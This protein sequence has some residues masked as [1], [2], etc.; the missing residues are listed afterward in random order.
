MPRPWGPTGVGDFDPY[1]IG[2]QSRKQIVLELKNHGIES[3]SSA[4]FDALDMAVAFFNSNQAMAESSKPAKVRKNIQNALDAALVLNDR[5]N[6]LDGNSRYLMNDVV[7]EGV[8]HLYNSLE[9]IIHSLS[10]ASNLANQYQKNGRLPDYAR[11]WLAVD[12]ASAIKKYLGVPPTTTRGGVFES[13]V[14]IMLEIA[15]GNVVSDVNDLIRRA[16]K[17]RRND[18]HPGFIE[19]LPPEPD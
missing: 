19:N 11:L 1:K 15:T 10:E 9:F 12:V 6:A 8:H 14:T 7:D 17:A 4:F 5:L 2:D 3:V 16:L 18:D 13:V